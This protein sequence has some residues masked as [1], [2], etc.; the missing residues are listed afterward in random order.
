MLYFTKEKEEKGIFILK[1]I[2]PIYERSTSDGLNIFMR[3]MYHFFQ[4][5]QSSWSDLK[6]I[7]NKFNNQKVGFHKHNQLIFDVIIKAIMEKV[8]I[9][10]NHPQGINL[11]EVISYV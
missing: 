8:Y 4:S 10:K 7:L 9:A 5:N 2:K 6:I 1:N 3:N 11:S